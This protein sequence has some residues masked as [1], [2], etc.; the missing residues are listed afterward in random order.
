[1]HFLELFCVRYT[2]A[3]AFLQLFT[4]AYIDSAAFL[5]SLPV[6]FTD[7]GRMN[8]LLLSSISNSPLVPR[9]FSSNFSLHCRLPSSRLGVFY[10]FHVTRALL[11]R[12]Y[13]LFGCAF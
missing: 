7:S 12:L 13:V 3:V 6:L 1:M 8:C 10:S 5:K 9:A 4:V 11:F 2:S